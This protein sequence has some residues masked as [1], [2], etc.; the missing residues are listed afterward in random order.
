MIEIHENTN[1]HEETTNQQN[2]TENVQTIQQQEIINVFALYVDNPDM[3]LGMSK[4]PRTPPPIIEKIALLPEH[5]KARNNA[6]SLIVN[7]E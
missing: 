2:Q 4:D 7:D 6:V 3:L 1:G 5:S